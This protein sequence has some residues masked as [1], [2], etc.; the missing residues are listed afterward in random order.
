[1]EGA[2][3]H[4]SNLT[5]AQLYSTYNY[6]NSNLAGIGLADA[7]LSGADF[8]NKSLYSV[9]FSSANL[10]GAQFTGAT[11]TRANFSS[12][13]L[14]GAE[15]TGALVDYANFSGTG[16]TLAQLYS[17]A[18]Y[19]NGNLNGVGLANMDLAGASFANK[20]L[21]SA[22]FS[23]ANLSGADFTGAFV[24][25][26]NFNGAGLTLAQL[27]STAS[28]ASDDLT[29][30]GLANTD[31]S[32]ANFANKSLYYADFSSTNLGN[33]DFTGAYVSDANFDKSNL[34][35]AQLYSTASYASGLLFDI[36]LA[37]TELS[38]ADFANKYFR[39][40]NFSSANL[41][42]ANLT[43]AN[44]D[45]ATLTDADFTNAEVRGASFS[46]YAS[47]W[48]D[49]PVDGT[50]ITLAQLYTT[51]S[52]QARDLS[53]ISFWGNDL[54]GGNFAGQNLT[55]ADFG[56]ATLTGADFTGAE[57]RGASLG[58][59][60]PAQLY[61]TASYQARNLT[62]IQLG[63]GLVGWNFAG[64]NLTNASFV[65]ALTDAD[66]TDAEV[67]GADFRLSGLTL[68]QLY[69]TAS[70][71]AHDLT[72]IA[73]AF[74]DLTGWNFAGQNLTNA[75]F[76]VA[77]LTGADF[78]NAN[79]RWATFGKSCHNFGCNGTGITLAQLY[80]TASYQAYD[81][82]GIDLSHNNLAGGNFAEQNLTNADFRGAN[83]AGA[84]FRGA[85]LANARFGPNNYGFTTLR[86]ADFSAADTRGAEDFSPP[87]SATTTNMIRSNGRIN[88]L[89]LDAGGML[90]VRDYDGYVYNPYP[91]L[92]IPITVDQHLA[93]CPGSTLRMVFEAD[94]WDSTI[95]FAPGIPVTL[96]GTLELTFAADVNPASQVGRTF[97]LFDWTGVDPAGAFSVTSPY[98]WD[99]S[100]LYTTGEVT[101]TAIPEPTSVALI[102]FAAAGLFVGRRTRLCA[103]LPT[104]HRASTAGLLD[105]PSTALLLWCSTV[106]LLSSSPAHADIFQ[107]EYI[108]PA[109]PSQ[110]KRQSTTLADGGAGIDDVPGADLSGRNLTMAYLIGADLSDADMSVYGDDFYVFPTVLTN[111]DLSHANLTNASFFRATLTGANFTGADV[112]G[113]NFGVLRFCYQCIPP[114]IPSGT[115]ITLSQLYS[116][117]SYQ[118]HDLSGVGFHQINLSSGN[119]AGQNLTNADFSYTTLTGADFTNA[120]V[121]GANLGG[122]SAVQLYSTASFLAHDLTATRFDEKVL[123]GWNFRGQNLTNSSF[124]RATLTGADF[125][126]AEVRGATFNNECVFQCGGT[127]ITPEQL[128]S[129]AS[130]R[131]H[132]LNGI[133]LRRARLAGANFAGQNLTNADFYTAM[134]T[135]ADFTGAK[136]QGA[137]FHGAG[138]TLA[139]LY[140]TASYQA[141]NLMGIGID[142]DLSGGNFVGQNL[143]NANF[144][145]ANFSG[146]DF[147]AADLRGARFYHFT[148]IPAGNNLIQPDGYIDRLELNSSATLV[149]RDYDG[150]P[151]RV[152]LPSG[153]N[154]PIPTPI[155]PISITIDR[156][157]VVGPGGTLRMVFDADVWDSTISF[158]PGIP[159]TLGGTLELT[160]AD[161]VNLATQVGR[162]FDLFNWTAVTPTGAFTISSPYRWNLSNLYT[163]G[164]VTLTS[165]PEP[166]CLMLAAVAL[167]V[168]MPR[169]GHRSSALMNRAA[170]RRTKIVAL[171]LAIALQQTS[172]HAAVVR[173][174]ALSGQPAPGTP[175]GVNYSSFGAHFLTA[176]ARQTYRGPVINNAG[177][178]AFRANLTGSG[179]DATNNQGVWSEGAGSLA[180]VART[181]DVA[182]GVPGGVNFGL[183]YALELFEPV[184][185]NVG[186]TAFYGGLTDGTVGLWSQGSGDLALVARDGT[187]A[188]GTPDDVNLSFAV[189]RDFFP[190]LPKLNDAGQVA[191]L[192]NV[193]GAGVDNTNDWG[194][195]SE[196]TGGLG[197]VAR[198]DSPAPGTPD[199]V[200][201]DSFFFQSGFNNAGQSAFLAFV[202]GDG[203]DPSNDQG[204][205]SEGSG[206]LALVARNGTPAPGTP[207]GVTFREFI[208]AAVA[209]NSMGRTT[210]KGFLTGEGVDDSNDEGIWFESSGTLALVARRGSPAPG[211][212]IGVN[213]DEFAV[214]PALSDAG[215]SAFSATLTGTGVTSANKQGI[216][217]GDDEDITLVARTGNQAPGTPAGVQF[218]NLGR[219]TVNS[220]GQIAFRAGLTGTGVGTA[221]SLG[222]W[223]TDQ[224][225]AL[226]LI[227][228]TGSQLEI[229]PGVFRTTSDLGIALDSGNS[230]GRASAFNDFGQLVFWASFTNGTQGVF[231][232]SLVAHLPG[233][234]NNDGTVD[235]ADYVVWRKGLGTTYTHDD[236]D[237][238]RAHFGD[239]L[240]AGIGSGGAG[241]ANSLSPAV[242][243]PTSIALAV[244]A[245]GVVALRPRRPRKHQSCSRPCHQRVRGKDMKSLQYNS[246]HHVAPTRRFVP[247]TTPVIA[248]VIGIALHETPAA[249]VRGATIEFDAT[250]KSQAVIPFDPDAVFDAE[251]LYLSG[252]V[253][254][255]VKGPVPSGTNINT[256]LGADAF[257]DQG[258][259]GTNAVVASIEAGHIWSGH[260]TLSHVLQI[261]NHPSALNEFDRHNTWVGA[262][263]GGR[264][265][266]AS[267]GAYQEGMAPNAQLYSGAIASQWNGPRFTQAFNFANEVVYDRYRKAFSS[268]VN[269][270]GRRADVI[271]SS[272]G[273]DESPTGTDTLSIAVDGFANANPGTLFVVSAGNDGPGPNTVFSPA[274]AYNNMS[275]AALGPNPPYDRPANFSSGGPN[276]Y[277]DPVNGTVN[278]ARQVVDIAAPG[279]MLSL[280]YYGGE[281]GGNG[282]TD[283]PSES[284]LGPTGLPAGPLGGPDYYSRGGLSG[285]SFASPTV[286]GGAALLYDAAYSVFPTNDDACDARVIKA[287][288]MNSAD[289]T[290]GWSNGQIAH[291]NGNGGVLTT[292]G[293][294]N[295]VG[296]GRMNLAA[297][298]DQFLS[299]TTDITGTLSGNL[300]L[301]NDIGWDFGQVVSGTTNDYYFDSPLDGGSMF[302][303]TLT[304]FRDRR[305]NASNTVFDDSYDDLNLELWSVV[306]GTPTSLISESSSLYNESEH[307][308]F[309]LPVTGEYALRVRWFK[310]V[311]DRVVDANQEFYGLAWATAA[312]SA[313][314][315]PEPTSAVLLF[316]AAMVCGMCRRRGRTNSQR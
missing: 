97:D 208:F 222:I 175:A 84:N 263:I 71:K 112:R 80:S 117:G 236:F 127:V 249:I 299:G 240:N 242:P 88:G 161:D 168:I 173:T 77:I 297:S 147:S 25:Y 181:G 140:S 302:T 271:N 162:T 149:V 248:M 280:A 238:W 107:W 217:L 253:P 23:S 273:S 154:V 146:A 13:N 207:S 191:F 177:Q 96:G 123:T 198:S 171:T 52:Y 138:I 193:T 32:G 45:G 195:W 110:G 219:Q 254:T 151:T 194:M 15:F 136:V 301:V 293:L 260:E 155:A 16:L 11:A 148:Q 210:F 230:D 244:A 157:F 252:R 211:T 202:T 28:Y 180:M 229:T 10:S 262:I 85:N 270:A 199:G 20:S 192:A 134:L 101:L 60:T 247:P 281:T 307:F 201:F 106:L 268:G 182:P 233:D 216:W 246:H 50:G 167:V 51:A 62:G 115:G 69:S 276:N 169:R 126:D 274:S 145:Y 215:L 65:G 99:L 24:D 58:G 188:P 98:R 179:I 56:A 304:W 53:G 170:C 14:S 49:C 90:V 197:L 36:G 119:F 86:D 132:D 187:P 116:T 212:P 220:A 43:N 63:G 129:T 165:V 295:R 2:N 37:N 267:P 105:S 78:T 234:F 311:F 196:R 264:Q 275:V 75:K 9:N 261:P 306:G 255:N 109:D 8:A 4:G 305:I 292:Q 282:T 286:A 89:D 308:S 120:E 310:E 285:T 228:R 189:L 190:G 27:Y 227:A 289:K 204:I 59:I 314:A 18:S 1:V 91:V 44:F 266:G 283:N 103:G 166:A 226:Q 93:M 67:R 135:D 42:G 3:F 206:G 298:Y 133:G 156:G 272:W 232:S 160:F 231:V 315:I 153:Y 290:V 54:S 225:G 38:G 81:L 150:D 158:A 178:V 241:S 309:A 87:S 183:N 159:V 277:R 47:C 296:T 40:A 31:L 48:F 144:S 184:L 303:A 35:L 21:Y 5:L 143:T 288:L 209:F 287:V 203:V 121:R 278:N 41:S 6:V 251:G 30:I 66:F 239:V 33:A 70:Y 111:A 76:H 214:R 265:G 218:S 100:N 22:S 294:D 243:E 83:L 142:G 29:G 291:P 108:N 312:L 128:Y 223:A 164:E 313:V 114:I 12:A 152:Y 74:N 176:I 200:N 34:I 46:T 257:Y 316:I 224:D 245:L 130:Y 174:V 7:D 118:A 94:D 95:S 61:S 259:T 17:T 68:A 79:V 185:N 72:G 205:W 186:Q 141:Q 139:Q 124:D 137:N 57:V 172:S 125:T 279:D 163:T 26:A 64:Q 113:A 235:S 122:F 258:F 55:N 284:G 102:L 250:A 19:V 82:S 39:G 269:L 237:V 92:L 131:A 104:R 256:L 73:L 221:N 300:G 213:F